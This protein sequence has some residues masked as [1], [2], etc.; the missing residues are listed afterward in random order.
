M[1]IIFLFVDSCNRA[2]FNQ[3]AI[4]FRIPAPYT[5]YMSRRAASTSMVTELVGW[6]SKSSTFNQTKFV[7]LEPGSGNFFRTS[8]GFNTTWCSNPT[9]GH[10]LICS[11]YIPFLN[12]YSCLKFTIYETHLFR[13]TKGVLAHNL[14]VRLE[15]V[16]KFCTEM[17]LP[18]PST[19][20][21]KQ[22]F[23]RFS[24]KTFKFFKRRYLHV[25]EI[26]S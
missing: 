23:T 7:T 16:K 10:Y 2:F 20:E 24:N 8:G 9:E 12:F 26:L 11:F 19:E 6:I 21:K 15:A 17:P 13:I 4:S 22:V 25:H 18:P 3:L 14:S 5:V 1:P